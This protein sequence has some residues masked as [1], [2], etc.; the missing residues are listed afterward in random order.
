[1]SRKTWIPA[2]A[3]LAAAALLTIGVWANSAA[4]VPSVAFT[5][6]VVDEEGAA[7]RGAT[8]S[9]FSFDKSRSI[10]VYSQ[11]DGAFV[12]PEVPA[13]KYRMRVRLIGLHDE[14]RDLRAD[15][16]PA[17]ITVGMKKATGW[18]LQ[19][20]RPANDLIS[21]LKWDNQ[22]DAL[23]F[24]MMCAYCH[25][26]GS[27]GFRSPE[28]PVDWEVM[29]TRMDGF[30]G[31]YKHTQEVLV[32]KVVSVYS[33]DAEKNWPEFVAPEGPSGPALRGEVREWVMGKEND[34][35]IHDLEVGLDGKIYTVDMTSDAI[36]VLDPVSNARTVYSFPGGKEYDS[37]DRPIKGPH[38]IEVDTDGNMWV[39]LAL[40]GEMGMLDTKTHEFRVG[41][42]HEAPRPRAGYPHTLEFAP[43]GTLWWT[44]A[45]L[46]VFSLDPKSWDG[47]RWAVTF[48]N[49]P[50]KDQVRG[51]GAR[52]E[53]Q[54]VTPYGIDV[55]ANG[56]VWYGK[57]NGERV[58]RIRPE[59]PD[60][61]PEKIVEWEPPVKGPRR[62][63]VAPNGIVWV[64]G[65]A[66]GDLASFDPQTEE[67]KVYGLP[68]GPD[69]LPYALSVNPVTGD[70]WICGTGTDSMLR[71]D[72]KT[73]Q[74]VEYR[75]PTRVTYTREIEFD[76]QGNAWVT[77]SNYPVRH[78]ENGHGSVIM[79]KAG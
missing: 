11:A 56:H 53:S 4:D 45:A 17:P 65:W 19:L 76:K 2:I 33:R 50:S 31:L 77:N 52:G 21:F 73:E 37:P 13:E 23:N 72:P 51:G 46:G 55:A 5:G 70:V 12:L 58:G 6:K 7:V 47:Q 48:Y 35:M 26:V 40:S 3:L 15:A 66:S 8:V 64:P 25:Q 29:L 62:L 68:H 1:M 74:F 43:N 20:Q 54:G 9:L 41:S 27:L 44:D 75:M 71:F 59:L 10:S 69:S 24:K 67:W 61:D 60:G 36:E 16:E 34:A 63:Q 28:E 32:D 14:W 22:A 39:T 18:A 49:L 78:V 57:L 38:S 30:Q 79:I 42:G